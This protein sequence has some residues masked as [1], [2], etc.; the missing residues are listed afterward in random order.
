MTRGIHTLADLYAR[1]R[2]DEATGCRHWLG[3]CDYK[4]PRVC[5]RL[6]GVMHVAGGRRAALALAGVSVAGKW[7]RAKAIC[8][9]DDCVAREH[10]IAET[11]REHVRQMKKCGVFAPGAAGRAKSAVAAA[12]CR[13][14]TPAQAAQ[15]RADAAGG[16]SHRALA[17]AHGIS[18][19]TV[20]SLLAGYTYRPM[21]AA[22]VW[23]WAGNESRRA[24]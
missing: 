6:A 23:A 1:C 21:P 13:K 12:R 19:G 24:A 22:S 11:R 10:A 18:R 8:P 4:G 2:H 14:L 3:G 15:V 16:L 9:S 20:W 17:A 5:F 7:T